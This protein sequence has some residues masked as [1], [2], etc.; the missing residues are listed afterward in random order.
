MSAVDFKKSYLRIKEEHGGTYDAEARIGTYGCQFCIGI[1]FQI[2]RSKAFCAHI[3]PRPD[4][5]GVQDITSEAEGAR[6]KRKTI[7]KLT[8]HA[9][10]NGWSAE[11]VD[12][13]SVV[14]SEHHPFAKRPGWYVID[15]IKEFLGLSPDFQVDTQSQGFVVGKDQSPIKVPF[16]PRDKEFEDVRIEALKDFVEADAGGDRSWLCQ[17]W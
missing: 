5:N 8:S 1:Y 9:K 7:E 14:M 17:D 15:G 10:E 4:G 3:R 13:A 11:D 2:G 16:D 12:K 6:L